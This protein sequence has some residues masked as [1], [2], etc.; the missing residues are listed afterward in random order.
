MCGIAGVM[1]FTGARPEAAVLERMGDLL[2][3]RGPDGVG[4]HTGEGIGLCHRRLSVIDLSANGHQPMPNE[5]GTLWLCVNGEIYNF[6][7]L[8]AELALLGHTF[9]SQT[10]SEVILHGYEAWGEGVL[11]RLRGMFA[12]A[13]YD[14]AARR[15]LLARDRL[16]IKP[17]YYWSDSRHCLF[18][19]EVKAMA[20]HPAFSTKP[21]PDAIGQYLALGHPTDDSS[22]FEGVNQVMPGEYLV[23]T[24]AG[25]ER[26]TYWELPCQVDYSRDYDESV[27]T[28]RASLEE[29]VDLHLLSDVPVG[30]HLSGG[31]DSS[32]IVALAARRLPDFHTFSAAFPGDPRFDERQFIDIVSRHCRTTH[33]QSLLTSEAFFALLKTVTWHMDE[34]CVGPALLPMYQVSQLAKASG[35]TVVN[36]GQGADE[37]F[38]GYGT[39]FLLAAR[40][41]LRDGW[42]HGAPLGEFAHLP[43]YLKKAQLGGALL[44]RSKLVTVPP[45]LL[46]HGTRV[47]D[48]IAANTAVDLEKCRGMG[49]FER[50]TYQMVRHYLRGL[51]HPEDRM[52]MA[53]SLESRVPLLDHHIVELAMSLPSWFKVRRGLGKTI[54]RDAIRADLPAAITDRRD[55]KGYPVPIG[56]WFRTD[57]RSELTGFFARGLLVWDFVDEAVFRQ[58]LEAHLD[59]RADDGYTIFKVLSTEVWLQMVNGGELTRQPGWRGEPACEGG[60]RWD[61][62]PGSGP[63]EAVLSL[64][65]ALRQSV[66]PPLETFRRNPA[67]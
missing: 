56:R 52:S 67:S 49:P 65:R 42:R 32:T 31:L 66:G 47:R 8:R 61:Q 2:A 62:A 60:G 46:R 24:D 9:R 17:L 33:H 44:R 22:W 15:L 40:N 18:A 34:P 55:K 51:L 64:P 59:G 19:S 6:Q 7:A 29:S 25:L 23:L 36:G 63:P 50:E 10:D 27:E 21:N 3:H 4:Y 14:G 13:L 26:R 5:D 28:L 54:M 37:L 12:I 48:R 35:V 30:A 53:W 11:Q 45:P 38:G 41:L 39:F 43:L 1:D 20:C 57:L 58:R 16:G